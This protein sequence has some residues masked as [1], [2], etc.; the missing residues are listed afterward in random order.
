MSIVNARRAACALFAA[1]ALSATPATAQEM[2]SLFVGS[3]PDIINRMVQLAGFKDGEV[4]VDLGSGDGRIVVASAMTH[5]GVRGWGVDI[6]EELVAQANHYALLDGVADRVKFLH[7]DVFDADL[8][9]VDVIYMWL[10]PE[11]QRLLR[12][13]I[14][15]EARPGTRIVSHL[16]DLGSWPADDT[17]SGN[18]SIKL[19]IVPAKVAGNWS[20][21]L[22]HN[23]A[24]V[25]YAA[26][27]EQNFSHAEGVVRMTEEKEDLRR[28]L[29]DV[30]LKGDRLTFT[31]SARHDKYDRLT[32]QYSG[33]VKGDRIEGQAR[34][35]IPKPAKNG[36][37]DG[38]LS[39]D[40]EEIASLPWVATRAPSSAFYE[41]K[42]LL[43]GEIKR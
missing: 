3:Q 20:W 27:M 30:K 11:L 18:S 7:G 40:M 1:C 12:T 16:F 24:N 2:F 22:S 10:F 41:R 42:Q 31:V 14:L 25:S 37:D 21:S 38:P 23:G 43:S 33:V 8:S 9:N 36:D 34:F 19:W 39:T 32:Q 28:E 15:A 29:R 5:K 35:L 17:D 26:V 4:A 6:N 13:K